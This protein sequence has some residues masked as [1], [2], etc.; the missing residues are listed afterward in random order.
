[1]VSKRLPKNRRAGLSESPILSWELGNWEKADY[2]SQI[3]FDDRLY[4]ARLL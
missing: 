4:L 2:S 3:R 1:M